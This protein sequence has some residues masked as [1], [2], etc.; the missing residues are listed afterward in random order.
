MFDETALHAAVLKGEIAVVKLLLQEGHPVNVTDIE[1]ETPLHNAI[2][3]ENEAIFDLLLEQLEQR[4]QL[5][6]ALNQKNICGWTPLHLAI[7]RH[8]QY[9][10]LRLVQL[11]ADLT[12]KD[13]AGNS[14]EDLIEKVNELND[15]ELTLDENSEDDEIGDNATSKADSSG[16]ESENSGSYSL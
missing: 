6:N 8:Q 14:P 12:I 15:L 13:E 3:E 5:N 9:M 11:N 1:N 7:L 16:N 2:Y 4:D 10:I